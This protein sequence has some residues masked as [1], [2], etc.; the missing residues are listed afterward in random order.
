MDHNPPT[1]TP[2]TGEGTRRAQSRVK[3][4]DAPTRI[5]HWGIV[6][7]VLICWRTAETGAMQVHILSGY[8]I[9]A[10][11]LF[12]LVWGL[13]GSDTARFSA[14][15]AS[16]LAALHHLGGFTRREPDIQIGHNAAGGW[17]VLLMLALLAAETVTGL[18]TNTFD[19]YDVN[20]SLA[21]SVSRA[22]SDRLSELHSVIFNLILA[23]VILHVLAV[24]AYA[25]LK[26]QNL[27]RPMITGSK[28][29]PPEI[30]RPRMRSGWLAT[31]IL[32][33]AAALVTFVA[34]RS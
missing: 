10:A 11:L 7:L 26:G 16:P 4:W 14:F 22:T 5:F 30:G 29:L 21:T 19:D 24:A 6:A 13:V 17:M 18:F 31:V 32:L 28:R 1:V 20:G 34:T 9:L 15:L 27:L 25:L 33:C 23:A 2:A 12:R 8:T 3:V